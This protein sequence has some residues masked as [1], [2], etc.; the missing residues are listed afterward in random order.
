[1]RLIGEAV[2]VLAGLGVSREKFPYFTY[3][4]RLDVAVSGRKVTVVIDFNPEE[5]PDI[6]SRCEALIAGKDR[7]ETEKWPLGCGRGKSV[8][9]LPI[10][11]ALSDEL[12]IIRTSGGE[13]ATVLVEH[14]GPVPSMLETECGAGV[15]A[16]FLIG[17]RLDPSGLTQDYLEGFLHG[18]RIAPGLVLRSVTVA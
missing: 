1:M 17:D 6:A 12:H 16:R 5:A 4:A 11:I 3:H 18:N 13:H 9:P 10:L 14:D 15:A 8:S 7:F 2:I